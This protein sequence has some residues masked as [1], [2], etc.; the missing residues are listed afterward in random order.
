MEKMD[1]S[2]ENPFGW[3]LAQAIGII[4]YLMTRADSSVRKGLAQ[5][6]AGDA[7]SVGVQFCTL[8]EVRACTK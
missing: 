5:V 3:V 4:T 2:E 6:F 1:K 7:K 8:F